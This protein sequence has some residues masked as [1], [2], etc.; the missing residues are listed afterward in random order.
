MLG[1]GIRFCFELL[2]LSGFAAKFSDPTGYQI[3]PEDSQTDRI[4]NAANA[5]IRNENAFPA[6][7]TASSAPDITIE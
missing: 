5:V 7:P 2:T 4:E 3:Y 6:G 1:N